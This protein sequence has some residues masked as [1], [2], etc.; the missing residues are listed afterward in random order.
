[1]N[2]STQPNE[3]KNLI[4]DMLRELRQVLD[5]HVLV[6]TLADLQGLKLSQNGEVLAIEGDPQAV[7]QGMVDKFVGLSNMVVVKTLQPLLRQCPW[8]KLPNVEARE[9]QSPS[10][11]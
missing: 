5:E 7:I 6:K 8:I 10:H 4:S 1:M 11:V 3:Y 9:G 2:Q